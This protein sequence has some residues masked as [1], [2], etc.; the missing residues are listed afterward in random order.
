[1]THDASKVLLGSTTTSSKDGIEFYASSPITFPAGTAVRRTNANVLSVAKAAG[2]YLGVSL[3]RS[4]SDTLKTSIVKAGLGIP[5]L[6]EAQPARGIVTITSY[7]DLV[8]TANDTLQVGATTFTFKTSASTSTEVLCA[9]SGSSNSVVA[10]ALV[11]KINAHTTAGALFVASNV[12]GVVTITAKNNATVGST[13]ALVYVDSSPTTVGL[14]TDDVTLTG[15]GAGA[16]Y[17]TIGQPVYISDTTGKADDPNSAS[18]ITN[19]FYS[20]EVLTGI[21]EDGSEVSVALIDMI[22]GL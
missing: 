21:A 2:G 12:N 8:D 3:G 1:M 20:S 4:L 16:D 14:T 18:T 7:A 13:V 19:A 15:G 9:A 10:A 11:V 6:L 17:V 22:G 5:I